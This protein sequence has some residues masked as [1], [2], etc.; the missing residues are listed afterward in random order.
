MCRKKNFCD[1]AVSEQSAYRLAPT[2]HTICETNAA[3][4]PHS[5][6]FI[7]RL[8]LHIMWS[9]PSFSACSVLQF[10]IPEDLQGSSSLVCLCLV[11]YGPGASSAARS[12]AGFGY[13]SSCR[14]G[15]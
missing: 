8:H 2:S 5:L 3:N 14:N 4:V 9:N 13:V 10:S 1:G 7:K 11:R 15:A 6:P 12:R